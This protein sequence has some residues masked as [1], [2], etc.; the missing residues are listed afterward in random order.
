MTVQSRIDEVIVQIGADIK[1][2][3]DQL[4]DTSTSPVAT[5]ADAQGSTLGLEQ[6]LLAAAGQPARTVLAVGFTN[7]GKVR[8]FAWCW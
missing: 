3:N 1:A 4:P 6:G 8:R 7:T 2:L 5:V